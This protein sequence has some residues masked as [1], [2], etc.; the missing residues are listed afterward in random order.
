LKL[1]QNTQQLLF[2]RVRLSQMS[3]RDSL[4]GLQ[5]LQ[6]AEQPLLGVLWLS[7]VIEQPSFGSFRLSQMSER[8]SLAGFR[9]PQSAQRPSLGVL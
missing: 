2:G 7:K 4:T 8:G 3:E 5:S 1:L 6:M 9:C